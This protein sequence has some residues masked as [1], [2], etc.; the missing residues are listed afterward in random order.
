M[1][2]LEKLAIISDAIQQTLP[3]SN[4]TILVELTKDLFYDLNKK[5]NKEGNLEDK[6]FKIDISGVSFYFISEEVEL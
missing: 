5:I 3:N 1:G 6:K 2:E 4:T